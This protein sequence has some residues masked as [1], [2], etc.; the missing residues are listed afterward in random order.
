M[1]ASLG[2]CLAPSK[3]QTITWTNDDPVY[4]CIYMRHPVSVKTDNTSYHGDL[5]AKMIL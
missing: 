3:R 2:Y 5:V 4:R 1:S